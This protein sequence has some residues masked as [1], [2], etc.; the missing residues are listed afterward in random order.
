METI[1]KKSESIN[2]FDDFLAFLEVPRVCQINKPI[3]KK[4]FLDATDGKKAILDATDKKA[5]KDD[6]LKIRWLYTL[7]PSTINIAPYKDNEREYPEVAMLHIELAS[8]EVSKRAVKRIAQFINRAIPYPLV[9]LFTFEKDEEEILIALADKR[10]NQADKE[11]WVIDELECS[12]WIKLGQVFENINKGEGENENKNKDSEQNIDRAFINSLNL[13]ELP[14]SSFWHFYQA[15]IN[16]VQARQCAEISGR[17][18]LVSEHE[19]EQQREQ[20]QQYRRIELTI[21]KLRAQIKQAEFS[22]QV[23]LNTE[24]KQQEQQLKNI[25]EHL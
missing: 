12:P 13:S 9:L 10:T 3:F 18:R 11:K 6:V 24:I 25:T 22:Q 14:F 1:N 7:K 5:L 19:A 4:M 21:Q 16:R 20:L 17:Y 8:S 15:L 2:I 23:V